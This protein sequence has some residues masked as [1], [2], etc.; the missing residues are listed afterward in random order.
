MAPLGIISALELIFAAMFV[1]L[2]VWS[3]VN[4]LYVSFGNLHMHDGVEVYVPKKKNP[5]L[6]LFKLELH[7]IDVLVSTMY[8]FF[9][10]QMES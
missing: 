2:L 3:I 7:W 1:T 6:R 5:F 4:Y 10:F 8:L 9:F